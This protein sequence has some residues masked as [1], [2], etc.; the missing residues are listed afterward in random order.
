MTE[1]LLEWIR[2]YGAPAVFLVVMA[3]NLGFMWLTSPAYVVAA[4]IVRS[5]R[6]GFWPM[7]SIIGGGHMVGATVAWAL[8]RAGE[9]AY[10]RHFQNNKHLRKVHKWLNRWYDKRGA[11]TLVAGRLIGQL[12]PWTSLAAGM[13]KMPAVPFLAWTAVGTV[14]YSLGILWV[15]LA[16]VRLWVSHPEWRWPIII[17]L[18]IGFFG[19]VIYFTIYQVRNN[20][21]ESSESEEDDA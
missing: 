8:M 15:Y 1:V 5:G 4:E 12:R 18:A 9:N 14:V 21:D 7:A 2:S 19:A 11:I 6:M 3:E 20:N 17:I 13:A 10:S 16:G